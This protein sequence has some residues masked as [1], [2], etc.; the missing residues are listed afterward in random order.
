MTNFEAFFVD[1]IINGKCSH[2]VGYM[3][4][5]LI[6]QTGLMH[7]VNNAYLSAFPIR[8]NQGER[9]RDAGGADKLVASAPLLA[10]PP[11]HPGL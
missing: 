2:L 4:A 8:N 6:R 9:H 10:F 1:L 11:F 7:G 5:G 3:H